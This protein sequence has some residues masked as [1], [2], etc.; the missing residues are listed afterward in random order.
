[1]KQMPKFKTI[2]AQQIQI[3]TDD[4]VMN[5]SGQDRARD[6]LRSDGNGNQRERIGSNNMSFAETPDDV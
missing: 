2:M 1:M 5:S 4:N 3:V 6:R